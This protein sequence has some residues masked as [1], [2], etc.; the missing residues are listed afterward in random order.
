[1][2][3]GRPRAGGL[4]KDAHF[5]HVVE[6]LFGGL[7]LVR[8]QTTKFGEYRWARGIDVMEDAVVCRAG[9]LGVRWST[10]RKT[11][12]YDDLREL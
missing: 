4:L 7:Q 10:G 3:R 6:D 8:S 2:E 12:G 11:F 1:M 9:V 5:L